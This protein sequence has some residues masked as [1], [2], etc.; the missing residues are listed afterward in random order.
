[1]NKLIFVILTIFIVGCLAETTLLSNWVIGT[2]SSDSVVFSSDM[3]YSQNPK[4]PVTVKVS[5]S[6]TDPLYICL[7][8]A[9][10]MLQSDLKAC[11]PN[12]LL[13]FEFEDKEEQE[14]RENGVYAEAR[15]FYLHKQRSLKTENVG[16]EP[17]PYSL[18]IVIQPNTYYY[19][20]AEW[21][22][23]DEQNY[24]NATITVVAS[25]LCDK[26]DIWIG[27]DNCDSPKKIDDGE[28]KASDVQVNE[29]K[30]YQFTVT[31][32]Q[33]NTFYT[34]LN[35]NVNGINASVLTVEV[36]LNN[37]PL[38]KGIGS[39]TRDQDNVN[40]SI[41]NPLPGTYYVN[42]TYLLTQPKVSSSNL[43]TIS[44]GE[45]ISYGVSYK[46]TSCSYLE[47]Q[48]T[49]DFTF[50]PLN[51]TIPGVP[52]PGE[53]NKSIEYNFYSIEDQRVFIVGFGLP[54]EDGTVPNVF[55]SLNQ[56]PSNESY[57]LAR[58]EADP[59]AFFHAETTNLQDWYIGV[60][61]N[62]ES[63]E[64]WIWIGDYG[65]ECAANCSS[66]GVCNVYTGVCACDSSYKNYLC[67]DKRLDTV[68]I[69]LI[70]IACAVVLAIAIGVPIA[71]YLKN[72]KNNSYERV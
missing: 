61:S 5:T 7:Q 45:D 67:S 70:A 16:D 24:V 30:T 6:S 15:S 18:D 65:Y 2:N 27:G 3:F 1:M 19:L 8:N 72:S 56:I 51:L 49:C 9:G 50:L 37:L 20:L 17:K 34:N 38:G 31:G 33:E 25:S 66:H 4:G 52:Q 46:T 57:L 53:T 41:T 26:G 35:V 42:I 60:Q 29:T 58:T 32:N 14:V 43:R 62:G 22:Q 47:N 39:V 68:W 13:T 21:E 64:Y 36:Q 10:L 63:E 59:V 40:V 48:K 71:C 54:D 69:V 44:A 12:S 55:V 11:N 28:V 23:T